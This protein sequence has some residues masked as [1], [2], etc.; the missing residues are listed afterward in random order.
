MGAREPD[1]SRGDYGP[2]VYLSDFPSL[3]NNLPLLISTVL[4]G[5]AY[6]SMLATFVKSYD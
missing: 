2:F 5:D 3:F 1:E 6:P 4:F